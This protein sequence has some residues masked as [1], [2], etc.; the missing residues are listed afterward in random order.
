MVATWW[1][2]LVLRD[3]RG[4]LPVLLLRDQL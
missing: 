3:G 1:V 2:R 4:R